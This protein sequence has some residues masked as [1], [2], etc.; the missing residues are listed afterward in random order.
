MNAEEK[1]Q[2]SLKRKLEAAN[3]WDCYHMAQIVW[4]SFT[5]EDRKRYGYKTWKDYEKH[6]LKQLGLEPK[7]GKPKHP[8]EIV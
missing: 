2:E 1:W 5:K 6:L 4:L 8:C 3:R 7:K